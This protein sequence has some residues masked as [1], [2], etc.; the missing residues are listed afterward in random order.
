MCAFGV[1]VRKCLPPKTGLL[2][3][4]RTSEAGLLVN[5]VFACLRSYAAY[6]PH[7]SRRAKNLRS[8]FFGNFDAAKKCQ[9][10]ILLFTQKRCIVSPT[11]ITQ[12]VRCLVFETI[13]RLLAQLLAY[14]SERITMSTVILE[15]LEAEPGD[16][17]E[18]ILA[19][20]QEFAIELAD[21]DWKTIET[22][23]DLTALIENRI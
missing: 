8:D 2:F 7:K 19:L 6:R 20:E 23:G 17:V 11:D 3:K 9:N 14:D 18:L 4:Q 15:D 12:E 13:Q 22:V 1:P 10:S 21:D 5:R 16:L